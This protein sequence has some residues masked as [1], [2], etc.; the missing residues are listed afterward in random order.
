MSLLASSPR[1]SCD[2]VYPFENRYLTYFAKLAVLLERQ[3]PGARVTAHQ[4]F[5]FADSAFGSFPWQAGAAHPDALNWLRSLWAK[6]SDQTVCANPEAGFYAEKAP[7]WLP[8][9]AREALAASTVYLFR[10]PRDVYLSTNA[11]MRKR[12]RPG[13]DRGANDTDLDYARTLAHRFLSYFENYQ[14]DLRRQNCLLAKY[15]EMACAPEEFAARMSGELSIDCHWDQSPWLDTHR[16][17]P[18][19]RASVGRWRQEALPPEVDRFLLRHLAEAM[20]QLGYETATPPPATLDFR[21]GPCCERLRHSPGVRVTPGED[22]SEVALTTGDFWMI[23]PVE[24]FDAAGVN[25]VWLSLRGA[26]GE[27]CSVY[28][29][30]QSEE[31]SEERSVHVP[32]YG[33][34]HWQIVRIPVAGHPR[35]RGRIEEL[36]VDPFNWREGGPAAEMTAALRWLRLVD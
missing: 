9:L 8:A 22:E 25:E 17:T 21:E 6:Y 2:R 31:F 16:T 33:G 35:W 23:L 5:D 11:F 32:Y 26:V 36:R 18:D 30:G 14:W 12:G 24:P 1:V 28:W 20:L 10:D 19:L 34:R 3:D 27:V 13:F 15:E 7:A 29:R 4:L